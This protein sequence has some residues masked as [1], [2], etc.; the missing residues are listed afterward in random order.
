MEFILAEQDDSLSIPV[1]VRSKR[2]YGYQHR[3]ALFTVLSRLPDKISCAHVDYPLES[4]GGNGLSLDLKLELSGQSSIEAFEMKTGMS[5]KSDKDSEITKTLTSLFVYQGLAPTKCKKRIIISPPWRSPISGLFNDLNF[6]KDT[7]RK[8]NSGETKE[9]VI[10]RRY[11]AHSFS[12]PDLNCSVEKFKE[13]F[14]SLD[15]TEGPPYPN[16]T[17][18]STQIELD[19]Q[20]IRTVDSLAEEFEVNTG[21]EVVPTT[22]II[23]ELLDVVVRCSERN[24]DI[25]AP[26]AT[27][28]AVCFARRSLWRHVCG[29]CPGEIDSFFK[30]AKREMKQRASEFTGIELG[31]AASVIP[32][33]VYG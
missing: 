31:E 11:K 33:E 9:Q 22:A 23:S 19:Q 2:G 14:L 25:M 26:L 29:K 18:E 10:D 7:K 17:P 8:N 6:F 1:I 16:R 3:F 28:L 5:F 27:A 4:D 30:S 32:E 15:V 21:F 20:L 12:S 24:I 13:F